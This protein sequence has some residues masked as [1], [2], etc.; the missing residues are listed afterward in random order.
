MR[1]WGVEVVAQVRASGDASL[2]SMPWFFTPFMW[3]YLTVC[4]LALAAISGKAWLYRAP[5]VGKMVGD[6]K[7]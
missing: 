7:Q 5:S 4:M 2:Y 3:T 1:P 6:A